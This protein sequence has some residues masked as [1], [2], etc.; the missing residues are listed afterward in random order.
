MTYYNNVA[1][2]V[3]LG[4]CDGGDGDAHNCVK[5][6]NLAKCYSFKVKSFVDYLK[7]FFIS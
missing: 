1:R 4:S 5:R 3:N 2:E 7:T 6:T